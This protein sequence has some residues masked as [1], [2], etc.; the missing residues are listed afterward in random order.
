MLQHGKAYRDKR[1]ASKKELC[2]DN[3]MY[4][5]TLKEKT[6]VATDKQGYEK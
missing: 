3:V 5:M 1:R 4:V 2:H 6:L